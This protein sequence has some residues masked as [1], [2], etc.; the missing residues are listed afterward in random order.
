MKWRK[1]NSDYYKK[2][3]KKN[4]DYRKEYLK[5]WRDK[6]PEYMKEYMKERYK[7]PECRRKVIARSTVG[8]AIKS[9]KLVRLPCEVC[10][11]EPAEAH[12]DNYNKPLEV[13]WLC[14][15]CHEDWHTKNIPIYQTMK[16]LQNQD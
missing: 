2:W 5:E 13:R 14:K 4:P 6:N 9:G 1:E 10:G 16:N 11:K 7:A 12:H 3:H 15:Q 8:C